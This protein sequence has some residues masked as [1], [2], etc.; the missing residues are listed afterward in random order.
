[1]LCTFGNVNRIFVTKLSLL[2]GAATNTVALQAR[3]GLIQLAFDLA[4][5]NFP[6]HAISS[7]QYLRIDFC[8]DFDSAQS[9]VLIQGN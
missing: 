4:S 2:S 9:P 5:A 6:Y 7:Y 3:M 8:F 1:M